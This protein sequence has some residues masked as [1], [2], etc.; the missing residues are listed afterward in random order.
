MKGIYR[1]LHA[2]SSFFL[3][4][5]LA[6]TSC[7]T[8]NTQIVID[9]EERQQ[10]MY[11]WE[12]SGRFGQYD[13]INNTYS[14]DWEP[15][16]GDLVDKLVNELGVNR[17]RLQ[18]KSGMEN[19]VDYWTQFANF[20]LT[21]EEFKSHFYEKI[22]DNDDPLTLD[23]DG[24][25]FSELDFVVETILLPMR[26][27]LEAK[28]EALY[29]NFNYID[30]KWTT[31]RGTLEHS[32]APDE[33]AEFVL[34]SFN[35]LKN[36]YNIVPHSLEIILEPDNTSGWSGDNI[37]RGL[38]KAV[39]RL[40]QAGYY[41][42]I[43]A[44]STALASRAMQYFNP[45]ISSSGV[46]D[47]ITSFSYHRYGTTS[48]EDI[49]TIASTAEQYGL[50][51]AM[52]EHTDGDINELFDDLVVGNVSAW[53]QW[54]TSTFE[55]TGQGGYHYKINPNS[56]TG[57]NV[58]LDTLSVPLSQLFSR[59]RLG[60]QRLGINYND[61]KL[62]PVAFINPDNTYVFAVNSADTTDIDISGLP[63]GDYKLT[64]A[65][66][67][68][69]LTSPTSIQFDGNAQTITA[70]RGLT[71]IY[72]TGA[73]VGSG[74]ADVNRLIQAQGTGGTGTGTGGN[75]TGVDTGG[76]NVSSGASSNSS[77]GGSFGQWILLCLI[78]VFGLRVYRNRLSR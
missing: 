15:Y 5:I 8:A 32:D 47:L 57:E 31:R 9:P 68:G 52:L 24:I 61:D 19:P 34:A 11:G 49:R 1:K 10:T 38:K 43:I 27:K 42:E 28:G 72:Q 63:V 13:K 12:I 65:S 2:P 25:Q 36:K 59:V 51:T 18:A 66:F 16:V 48:L 22:N 50:R 26:Q 44:P 40:N 60:A 75:G 4:L 62:T 74:V 14:N 30:F 21:Y 45:M 41:P 64:H 17:I 56:T 37:A 3:L 70:A 58:Y 7:A 71:T 77:S 67:N 53:Q 39:E 20:Q 54:G 76:N 23:P 55:L 6:H 78:G 35:H 46:A 69:A 33:Y 29:I 73:G